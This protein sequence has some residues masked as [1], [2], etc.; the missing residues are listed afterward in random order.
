MAPMSI[1]RFGGRRSVEPDVGFRRDQWPYWGDLGDEISREE[2][3]RLLASQFIGR[4]AVAEFGC[5]SN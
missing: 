4:V 1:M 3:F 2:C 5:A